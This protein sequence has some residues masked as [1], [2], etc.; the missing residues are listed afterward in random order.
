MDFD[1]VVLA[2]GGG[3]RLGGADKAGLNV[4]GM[5]LLDRVLTACAGARQTVVVG[6][7][8]PTIR[9]V[10]WTLEQPPGGGP[11]AGLAA[12][13]DV[14]SRASPMPVLVL[15]TDLPQLRSD[16]VHRLVTALAGAEPRVA[17]AV[18]VDD[19]Q[20]AQPLTA[21]YRRAALVQALADEQPVANRPMHAML[22][23]L[24][25]IAVPA[26]GAAA[27]I[28]TADQLAAARAAVRDP[29]G[30]GLPMSDQLQDWVSVV[31][32]AKDIDPAVIDV[33]AVLDLAKDAA[34]GIARPAAPLTTFMAGYLAGRTG[35]SAPATQTAL[36]EVAALIPAPPDLDTPS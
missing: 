30:K 14:L 36:E 12:G 24:T 29:T 13:V 15:A 31:C 11:L 21:I 10:E 25:T 35:G 8:R 22:S 18:F 23:R 33:A 26:G 16:D 5:S 19:A 4:G 17:G 6:T 1:A 32:Q 20:H 3:T 7:P 28:D 9:T 2:G 27:D 34:H